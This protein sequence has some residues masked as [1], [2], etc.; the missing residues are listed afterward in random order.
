MVVDSSL[1]HSVYAC[2]RQSRE[3]EDF[4]FKYRKFE[5]CGKKVLFAYVIYILPFIYPQNPCVVEVGT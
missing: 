5:S 3:W 1:G 4:G 2:H